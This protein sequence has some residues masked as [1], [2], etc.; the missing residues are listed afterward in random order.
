VEYPITTGL[1]DKKPGF[2]GLNVHF[3]NNLLFWTLWQKIQIGLNGLL[4]NFLNVPNKRHSVSI[5]I[6]AHAVI[7]DMILLT[8][9]V[10]RYQTYFPTLELITPEQ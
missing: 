4:A 3:I 2:F 1:V 10:N 6:D 5:Y 9:D 8:R 7:A